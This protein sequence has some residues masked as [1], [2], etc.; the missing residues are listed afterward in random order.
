ML[1]DL[2]KKQKGI[3]WAIAIVFVLSMG[4]AGIVELLSPKP[5]VGKIYG[6]KVHLQEFDT[7]YRENMRQHLMQNQDATLDDQTARQINDQT[8]NQLVSRTVMEKQLKR[9]RIRVRDREVEDK[10][11]TDPPQDV[12]NI[13]AFH[14]NGEFDFHK[15]YEILANEDFFRNNLE[16]YIRQILPYEK[17]ERKIKDQVVVTVDSVRVDWL[18]RNDRITGRVIYFD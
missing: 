11:L 16:D 1:D 18:E 2:R 8:W 15:Y 13:A 7:M 6:K 14:T 12:R 3:I 10:I 17:L 5:F 9:Y 4:I